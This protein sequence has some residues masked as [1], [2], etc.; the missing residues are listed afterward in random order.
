MSIALETVL[1]AIRLAGSAAP[2]FNALLDVVMPLLSDAD[3]ATL[4]RVYEAEK[5]SSD[6]VHEAIQ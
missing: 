2:A 5:K 3:Q 6:A 4:K 1:Q